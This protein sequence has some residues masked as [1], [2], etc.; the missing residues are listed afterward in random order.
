MV[1]SARTPFIASSIMRRLTGLGSQPCFQAGSLTISWSRL[2]MRA[3]KMSSLL[4]TACLTVP[5]QIKRNFWRKSST[6]ALWSTR[7]VTVCWHLDG[8]M[9]T[10]LFRSTIVFCRQPM[11]KICSAKLQ[12]SMD[13]LLPGK[14]GKNPDERQQK[15][16]LTWSKQH[17][18]LAFLQNMCCSTV[19]FHHRRPLAH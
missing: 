18:H 15:S 7:K 8:P 2:R 9:A 12:T 4:M 11:I 3:A 13:V 16:W 14:G 10:P 6:T 19:G 1:H 5:V 17:N